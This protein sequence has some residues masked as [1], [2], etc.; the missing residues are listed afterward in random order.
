MNYY[1]ENDA[2]T[3]AWLRELIHQGHIPAGDV[4]ERSITE[5]KSHEVRH[6]IQRHWFA[7]I[8]GWALALR[9]AGWPDDEP[10]DTGVVPANRFR[11]SAAGSANSTN[12]ISGHNL[13]V[14]LASLILQRSLASRLRAKTDWNGSTEYRLTWRNEAMPSLRVICRLQA[15]L[16][17]TN[18][19]ESSGL[20]TPTAMEGKDFGYAPSLLAKLDRGGV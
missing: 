15:S 9:L 13:I 12:A 1:N 17:T 18:G 7:G 16:V 6:Y 14:S 20:P 4:D 11:A 5:V 3:A 8:G 10:I 19:S 2:P